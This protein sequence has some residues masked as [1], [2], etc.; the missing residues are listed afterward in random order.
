MTDHPERDAPRRAG[1]PTVPPPLLR[2]A[3]GQAPAAVLALPAG[4]VG[5]A[6]AQAAGYAGQALA[7][8]VGAGR[9]MSQRWW[10]R[11]DYVRQRE[12]KSA[13]QPGSCG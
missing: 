5:A 13:S 9:Q 12:C 11:P 1:L 4:P 2:A 10:P 7:E 6:V 3:T 8:G